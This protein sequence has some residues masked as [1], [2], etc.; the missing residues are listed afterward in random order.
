MGDAHYLRSGEGVS[1]HLI[2]WCYI[3]RFLILTSKKVGLKYVHTLQY[4]YLM[5]RSTR[6]SFSVSFVVVR[7]R[8]KPG[9]EATFELSLFNSGSRPHNVDH[10]YIHFIQIVNPSTK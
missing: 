5:C 8:R 6:S 10:M 9:H 1:S 4:S 7:Q 3:Y 2:T